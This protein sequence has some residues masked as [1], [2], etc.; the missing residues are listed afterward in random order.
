MRGKTQAINFF[1]DFCYF[2]VK[3]SRA[4]LFAGSFFALL[5]VSSYLADKMGIYRYDLLF[6]GA[7]LIQVVLV[8]LRLESKDEAK[9]IFLFHIIGV[10]LEIYKTSD[11]VGSWSYPEEGYLKLFNVPIYSGFMYA[12]VGSYIAHAWKVFQLRLVFEIGRA[13]V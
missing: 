3:Q 12:A 8:L 10:V 7:V 13:H 4:A 11:M 5:L 6:V 2:V 9:L 1:L